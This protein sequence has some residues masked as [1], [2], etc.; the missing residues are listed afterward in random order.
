M[1]FQNHLVPPA[2][3]KRNNPHYITANDLLSGSNHGSPKNNDPGPL[4]S[5]CCYRRF[6]LPILCPTF[7]TK[8]QYVV[9]SYEASRGQAR[10]FHS[11]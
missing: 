5:L 9:T 11:S 7:L 6:F 10:A 1:H 2:L 8:E 4:S 3:R